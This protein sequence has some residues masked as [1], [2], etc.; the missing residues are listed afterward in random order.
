M[1]HQEQPRMGIS[2]II[3][4][5]TKWDYTVRHSGMNSLDITL[6][7]AG[8]EIVDV[9]F[10]D[11]EMKVYRKRVLSA[12]EDQELEI[13]L[14]DLLW[15]DEFQQFSHLGTLQVE[16]HNGEELARMLEEK[17][18]DDLLYVRYNEETEFMGYLEE[19]SIKRMDGSRTLVCYF[20]P[21]DDEDDSEMI[22]TTVLL[23]PDVKAIA[24]A[25]ALKAQGGGDVLEISRHVEHIH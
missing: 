18:K 12:L 15:E 8:E 19:A 1:N 2:S 11:E 9:S 3:Y 4:D 14:D 7:R 6:T 24:T 13:Y 23:K 20:N 22:R 17:Y 25:N 10:S 16:Y 5:L 21:I